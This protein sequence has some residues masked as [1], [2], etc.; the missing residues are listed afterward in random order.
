[1]CELTGSVAGQ[2]EPLPDFMT[3]A[4]REPMVS[5]VFFVLRGGIVDVVC[6]MSTYYAASKMV[7]VVWQQ[8]VAK[9]KIV[10]PMEDLI[11][12]LHRWLGEK[13]CRI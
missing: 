11:S 7:V 2:S 5:V 3:S 1:M 13:T 6:A 9:R 12:K 4:R 10:S 8:G